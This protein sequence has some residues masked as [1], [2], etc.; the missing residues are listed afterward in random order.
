MLR[1]FYDTNQYGS[2]PEI[3]EMEPA[4]FAE[5]Q[6]DL[7]PGQICRIANEIDEEVFDKDHLRY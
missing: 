1:I 2:I 3:L 6:N 7:L 5:F 4:E